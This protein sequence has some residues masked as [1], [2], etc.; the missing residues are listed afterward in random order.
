MTIIAYTFLQYRRLTKAGRGKKNRLTAASAEPAC[1]AMS[2]AEDGLVQESSM[3]VSA[4]VVPGYLR[5]HRLISTA[6]KAVKAALQKSALPNFTLVSIRPEM[7]CN[8]ACV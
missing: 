8:V 3:N 6:Q 5:E 7:K 4:K 1:S 2:T